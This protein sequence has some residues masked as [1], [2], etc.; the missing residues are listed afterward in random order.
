VIVLLWLVI[1]E[2]VRFPSE[3]IVCYLLGSSILHVDYGKTGS[4]EAQKLGRVWR[5]RRDRSAIPSYIFE[6][7]YLSMCFVLATVCMTNR[8][9]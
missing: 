5:S 7:G 8:W 6:G 3:S 9:L 2:L 4:Q 1:L